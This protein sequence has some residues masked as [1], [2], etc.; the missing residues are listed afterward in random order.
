MKVMMRKSTKQEHR[1]PRILIALLIGWMIAS[2]A[3]FAF[4]AEGISTEAGPEGP[5]QTAYAPANGK[6]GPVIVAISGQSG[7]NSYQSY[8]A[9][10][11]QLGYYAVLLTGKDI[12]NPALTGEATLKKAIERAQ[13]SPYAIPGKVAVIGFSLG[14]GGALYNATPLADLVS[15]VVAYYPYTKTWANKMDG[16]VKRFRVPVLVLAGQRDRYV[17]CC[18]IESMQA[19]EAAAKANNAKFELVVYPEANHGFN[20]KTGAKGEPAG[21]YR[22]DDDRDAW[23][24]TV[25]ML[26]RYQPLK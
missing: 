15:V 8:V 4:A 11:A 24:R 20:L 16:F 1:F 18:V 17:E 13:H 26:K 23:R 9:E 19:M 2:A 7:P 10:L 25:E 5:A 22:P 3:P 12:L 14:G 21:A 6:P